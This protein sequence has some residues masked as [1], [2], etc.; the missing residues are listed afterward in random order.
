LAFSNVGDHTEVTMRGELRKDP[1]TGKWV[2]VR[3][4][5]RDGGTDAPTICPFCPG[6]EHLTPREITAYRSPH[7]GGGG[8]GWEVRVVPELDPYFVIEEEL[9]REGIGMFDR[10]SP[11]GASEI[12]VESP[13]HEMALESA[14]DGQI[15]RILWMYRDRI[16]DLKRDLKIRNVVVIRRHGKPGSRIR[17]PYSRVLAAPIVFDDVRTELTQAREYYAYKRRCVFCDT[18]REVIA[19]RERLVQLTPHFVALVPYAARVPFELRILPRRHACGFETVSSEE[20][21]DLARVLRKLC[22]GIVKGVGEPSYE[23]TLHTAPNLAVK[24]VQ[25]EWDTIDRD[26]HWHLEMLVQPER[27]IAVSG[28]AVT[29]MLPEEA[30]RVLREAASLDPSRD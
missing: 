22:A 15:E 24:I 23:M 20:V 11:R 5:P 16:Q 4:R 21:T 8:G 9:V 13:D 1:V 19:T 18:V 17:H 14:D 30:A 3:T 12:V 25:G 10:I 2:L 26:Y 27:A 29:D 7:S 28:I 6:N